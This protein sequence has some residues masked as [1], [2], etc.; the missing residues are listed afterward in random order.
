MIRC[1]P[2]LVVISESS[3]FRFFINRPVR[4]G[5]QALALWHLAS[6]AF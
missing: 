3:V 4:T 6:E 5:Y 1:R 2:L